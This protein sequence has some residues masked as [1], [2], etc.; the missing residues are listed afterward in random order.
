[1]QLGFRPRNPKETKSL[2]LETGIQVF[3]GCMV[4]VI[5]LAVRTTFFCLPS[6]AKGGRFYIFCKF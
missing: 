3:F 5:H 4:N 2:V 6:F 1:M